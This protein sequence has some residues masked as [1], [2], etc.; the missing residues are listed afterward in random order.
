MIGRE[1]LGGIGA[2]LKA[3]PST[4]H[5]GAGAAFAGPAGAAM[6]GAAKTYD[7]QQKQ[8]VEYLKAAI[9]AQKAGDTAEYN[10]NMFQVRL[11]EAQAYQKEQE[12]AMASGGGK[13]DSPTQ[14]YLAAERLMKPVEK[15]AKDELAGMA[16]RGASPEEIEARRAQQ[17]QE[18]EA[19]RQ[20]HYANLG[21][22]PVTATA[23]AKMP[24]NKEDNP[25]DLE[26]EG[27]T[28][29]TIHQKLQPGQFY[30]NPTNAKTKANGTAGKIYRYKGKQAAP[31]PTGGAAP[32]PG[33]TSQQTPT[34][35][36]SPQAS[37][38]DLSSEGEET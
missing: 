23:L 28:E 26:K 31:S 7:T 20:G 10:R 18:I 37:T 8:A 30:R 1:I 38:E 36:S 17:T 6:E 11:I 5:S 29:A 21:I 22:H 34:V 33:P 27:I 19:K 32:A 3:V 15:D 9:D 13:L 12:K 14:L 4:Y 16:K 24:G 2:G 35:P 25:I